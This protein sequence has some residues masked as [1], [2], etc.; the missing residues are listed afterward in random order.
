MKVKAVLVLKP[1]QV[2]HESTTPHVPNLGTRRKVVS[3]TA[4][5]RVS[6]THWAR[7]D[8]VKKNISVPA[9]N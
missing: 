7:L 1:H 8:A 3:F 5:R 9:G 6:G 2:G 4:G